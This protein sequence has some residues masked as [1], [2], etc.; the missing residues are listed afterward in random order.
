MKTDINFQRNIFLCITLSIIIREIFNYVVK[1]YA[2]EILKLL[3]PWLAWF[4]G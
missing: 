1:I 2:A 3:L 4:S